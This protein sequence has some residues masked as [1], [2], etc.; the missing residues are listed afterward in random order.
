MVK[1]NVN[2]PKC[3]HKDVC[4]RVNKMEA[5]RKRLEY[6]N[7]EILEEYQL[8]LLNCDQFNIFREKM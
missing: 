8:L 6:E 3:I 1:V 7:G 4:G 5:D 2:C